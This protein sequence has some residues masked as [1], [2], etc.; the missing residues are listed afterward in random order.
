M[1]TDVTRTSGY[2]QLEESITMA[3]LERLGSEGPTRSC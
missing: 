2:R 1:S 3:P